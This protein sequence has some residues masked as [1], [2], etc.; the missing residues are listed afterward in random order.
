MLDRLKSLPLTIVLTI[1]VWMYA[2]A[3]FTSHREDITVVLHV[4]VPNKDY[5]AQ[6]IDPMEGRPRQAVALMISV[7]GA[8][9]K[10]DRLYQ[11][12]IGAL[13]SDDELSKLVYVVPPEDLQGNPDHLVETVKILNGL[14]YF[15]SNGLLVTAANP[16]RVRIGIV[17]N[18]ETTTG[19]SQT[20]P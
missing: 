10:V 19:A 11:Q 16:P 3:Q 14:P 20:A 8:Q 2:E 13:V 15:R 1:L 7:Q 18:P 6:V 9:A 12:A 17:R 4:A 5:Q